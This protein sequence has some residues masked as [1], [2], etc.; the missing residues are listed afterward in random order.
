MQVAR[1]NNRSVLVASSNGNPA[2][3]DSVLR[4]LTADPRRWSS[5]DGAALVAVDDRTPV[6]I[7][8]PD[9]QTPAASAD[10]EDDSDAG[11]IVATA[12]AVVAVLIIAGAAWFVLRRRRRRDG[13]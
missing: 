5:L 4:W 6:M 2:Q 11:V 1:S 12:G 7:P 3:L 8:E 9:E 13:P 10:T